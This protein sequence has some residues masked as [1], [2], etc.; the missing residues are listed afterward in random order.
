[1]RVVYDDTED[2]KAFRKAEQFAK[3]NG[4]IVGSMARGMPIGLADENVY[5]YVAKW[6]NMTSEERKDLLGVIMGDK[7]NGPV[8]VILFD[9]EDTLENSAKD[10]SY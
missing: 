7:R 9:D 6:Y 2:F 4:M 3:A 5:G 10:Y 8:T 1:M